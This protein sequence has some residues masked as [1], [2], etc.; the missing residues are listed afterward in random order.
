MATVESKHR[1]VVVARDAVLGTA[2]L[3]ELRPAHGTT[4]IISDRRIA[5]RRQ[6]AHDHSPERRRAVDRRGQ[7]GHAPERTHR[8]S[9]RESL[10]WVEDRSLDLAAGAASVLFVLVLIGLVRVQPAPTPGTESVFESA[11][12]VGTP[13]RIARGREAEPLRS[14]RTARPKAVSPGVS[15]APVAPRNHLGQFTATDLSAEAVQVALDYRYVGDQGRD[16]VF[17]HVAALQREDPA[18]RVPGTGFP[19][20]PIAVGSGHVTITIGR[21]FEAGPAAST[22]IRAC[23]VS[24]RTRS[25]FLC[26]T[27]PFAKAWAPPPS[28]EPSA[29]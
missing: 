3:V 18:S 19:G 17:V 7:S 14:V 6:H 16:H 29:L 11:P 4:T 5:E 26:E 12:T 15:T 1:V 25:A 8:P 9:P 21:A 10:R 28:A 20:A 27:F 24:L 2:D 23:M 22:H 13:P